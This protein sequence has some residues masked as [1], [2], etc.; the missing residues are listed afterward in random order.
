M[1][2]HPLR[3]LPSV[4]TLLGEELGANLV[5]RHGRPATVEAI[6]AALAGARGRG[7]ADGPDEL[8]AEAA[9]L[10][11]RPP[12]LRPA[13][14]RVHDD[15]GRVDHGPQTGR[16]AGERRGG[17]VRHVPRR[18]VAGPAGLEYAGDSLLDDAWTE[19]CGRLDESRVG[20]HLVGA[21]CGPPGIGHGHI[22]P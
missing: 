3:G 9:R 4:D 13:Q 8:L 21:R 2:D 20:E 16:G 18:D 17:N 22:L 1:A 14:V 7:V 11:G 15:P 10:L 19:S 12:S 5:E 6:R